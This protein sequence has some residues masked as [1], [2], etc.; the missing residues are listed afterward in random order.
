MV[1][2]NYSRPEEGVECKIMYIF[3]HSLS[4]SLPFPFVS[5]FPLIPR[6]H[7][8]SLSS[9][10]LIYIPMYFLLAKNKSCYEAEQ[11]NHYLSKLNEKEGVVKSK[12]GDEWKMNKNMI[13]FGMF[14]MCSYLSIL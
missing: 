14:I 9:P 7:L 6:A 8:S 11:R 13:L 3:F 5:L 4:P 12:R 10:L 2:N 1:N